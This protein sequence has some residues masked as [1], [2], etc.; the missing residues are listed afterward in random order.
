MVRGCLGIHAQAVTW[1]RK[2]AEHGKAISQWAVG[3]MFFYGSGVEKDFAQAR[4]WY[5]KA[6]DQGMPNAMDSLGSMYMT[7]QGVP[8]DYVQAAVWFANPPTSG[9]T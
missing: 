1:E 6:A 8:Q 3:N 7:G 9:T 4:L 2:A 5:R